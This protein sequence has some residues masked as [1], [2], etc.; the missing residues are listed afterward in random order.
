M[1][2]H[3]NC[4]ISVSNNST[5]LYPKTV[6]P[7]PTIVP[8]R[9]PK[10]YDR[11]T[12]YHKTLPLYHTVSQSRT[13][14]LYKLVSFRRVGTVRVY[15]K[16]VTRKP[17]P[18]TVPQNRT[19]YPYPNKD[20]YRYTFLSVPILSISIYVLIWVRVRGTV[21]GYGFRV[22]FFRVRFSGYGFG[23]RFWGTVFRVRFWSTVLGYGTVQWYGRVL[24]IGT[25]PTLRKNTSF[26]WYIQ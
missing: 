24:S 14:K 4:A 21:L 26:F 17:Y 10:P 5:R 1:P 22:R 9:T 25:L 16:T 12:S 23:V 2:L 7:Y 8:N 11:T 13:S 3:A 20:I 6:P 15:P 18:K 19:P